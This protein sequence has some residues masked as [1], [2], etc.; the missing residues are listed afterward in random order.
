MRLQISESANHCVCTRAST[1]IH[2][3][4]VVVVGLPD[5][6]HDLGLGQA[7]GLDGSLHR[8]GP[9]WVVQGQVLQAGAGQRTERGESGEKS[10]LLSFFFLRVTSD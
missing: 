3:G 2:G 5:L 7:A 10:A 9:L 1:H 6:L 4:D 8:D